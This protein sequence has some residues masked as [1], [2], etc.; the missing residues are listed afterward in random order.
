MTANRTELWGSVA[1]CIAS[2]AA[3]FVLVSIATGP[4]HPVLSAVLAAFAATVAQAV[5]SA[6]IAGMRRELQRSS[7]VPDLVVLVNGVRAGAIGELDYTQMKLDTMLD[8]RTYAA[9]FTNLASYLLSCLG[10]ATVMV[11]IVIFWMIVVAS[12][13]DPRA[14]VANFTAIA[15]SLASAQPT[16]VVHQ[17]VRQT[18]TVWMTLLAT[19]AMLIVGATIAFGVGPQPVNAFRR[20]LLRRV[21]RHVGCTSEGDVSVH[22][23]AGGTIDRAGAAA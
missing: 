14:V 4:H 11:P 23:R 1:F 12:F 7:N 16:D 22:A 2:A 18:G 8:A 3:A 17:A 5:R 19:A 15:H 20:E 10:L 21:R 13:V 9:Q 6:K